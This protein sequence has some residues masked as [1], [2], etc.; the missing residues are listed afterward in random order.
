[1]MYGHLNFEHNSLVNAYEAL[2]AE[3]EALRKW[4]EEQAESANKLLDH[5]LKLCDQI[6]AFKATAARLQKYAQHLPLC[7]ANP[8]PIQRFGVPVEMTT[9]CTCGLAAALEGAKSHDGN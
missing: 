4:G 6:D 7:Q 1:M 8:S 5:G 2:R 9:E 3:N